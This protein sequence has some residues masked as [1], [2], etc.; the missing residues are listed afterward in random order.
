MKMIYINENKKQIKAG[1]CDYYA[2]WIICVT[3]YPI[4]PPQ[5]IGNENKNYLI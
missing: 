1:T 3:L 5:E 4:L 2:I